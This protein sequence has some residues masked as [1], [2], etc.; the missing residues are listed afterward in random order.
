MIE[1]GDCF[2]FIRGA[3]NHLWFVLTDPRLDP[4]R[5]LIAN[6]TTW[7]PYHDQSC[8][9]AAGEHAFIHHRTCVNAAGREGQAHP[10]VGGGGR[11]A[12]EGTQ[13]RAR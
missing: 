4:N 8:I 5:I 13:D 2:R 10:G 12:E 6:F 3:E 7:R 9:L 1:A 11:S